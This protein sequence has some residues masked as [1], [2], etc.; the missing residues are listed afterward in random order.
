M[1]VYL[2][3]IEEPEH[4]SKFE[5]IYHTYRYLL[6]DIAY[7][8]LHNHQDAEDAVHHTFVKIAENI[9]NISPPCPKTRHFVVIV[10]ENH[11]K[12]ILASRNRHPV[13]EIEDYHF[14]DFDP[15]ESADDL[16]AQCILQLP[17]KQRSVIWLKYHYGY[18][19]REIA[20][21]LDISLADAQ[22]NDYRAKA[23]L[24]KIYEENGGII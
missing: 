19:L 6:Y 16:L 9:K 8:K 17:P 2:S 18:S 13:V 23:Q 20:N 21:M 3:M 11:I 7:Q 4:H 24:K 12:N 14:S 15:A 22:K 1:L 5:E 10:I